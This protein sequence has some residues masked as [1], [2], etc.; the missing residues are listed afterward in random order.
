MSAPDLI[1]VA[2][3]K[4]KVARTRRVM[5]K[6]VRE[7]QAQQERD[8]QARDRTSRILFSVKVMR[9]TEKY[10]YEVAV[11]DTELSVPVRSTKQAREDALAAWYKMIEGGVAVSQ[12]LARDTGTAG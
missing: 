10:P 1:E 9:P 3:D 4:P 5:A 2:G 6:E 7:I 12:A 11:F 8:Q